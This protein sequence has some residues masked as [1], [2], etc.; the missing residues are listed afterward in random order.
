MP[1]DRVRQF[2]AAESFAI[3]GMS[4]SRRN[5]TWSICEQLQKM[6]R[7]VYPVNPGGG[8]DGGVT[9]YESLDSLPEKPQAIIIALKPSAT[10]EIL[11]S[12]KK[13]QAEF[14]WLQQGSY[15]KTVLEQAKRF[16]LDPIGGCVFMYMPE[17]SMFH[18]IHRAV[19][20]FFGKGYK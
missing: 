17:A 3:L 16:G 12:L 5:F 9:F 14:V 15:N 20:D 6:G 7:R 19:N 1:S 2:Y 11:P 8:S 4:R 13:I 18:A 10:S